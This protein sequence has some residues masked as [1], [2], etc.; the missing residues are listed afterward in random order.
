MGAVGGPGIFPRATSV[1][2]KSTE[3]ACMVHVPGTA[4]FGSGHCVV[5]AGL[6]LVFQASGTKPK[7]LI[8]VWP[9]AVPQ[10]SPGL[11]PFGQGMASAGFWSW[12]TEN[13]GTNTEGC[14]V[15]LILPPV[16]SAE[17]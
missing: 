4:L 2:D 11:P 9:R 15:C 14:A 8:K 7:S 6:T 3:E 12:S 1:S 17:G 10:S 13:I 5:M 16:G